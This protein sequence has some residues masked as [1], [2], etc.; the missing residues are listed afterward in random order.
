MENINITENEIYGIIY[1]F[2]FPNRKGYIGQTIQTPFKKRI[3]SHINDT[4]QN[5]NLCFHNALR[6]FITEYGEENVFDIVEV[7]DIAYS[8]EELNGLEIFYIENLI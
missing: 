8:F 7:I 3:K 5:S 4:K 6:K 2:K 1:Y